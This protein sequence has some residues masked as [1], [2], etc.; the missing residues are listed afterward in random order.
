M[1]KKSAQGY[2]VSQEGYAVLRIGGRHKKLHRVIA[3]KVLGKPLPQ[4]SIVHHVNENR[5]DNR[6]CNL[7]IC[8]DR[9]YHNYIHARMRVLAAGLDPNL[10]R[11]CALGNHFELLSNFHNWKGGRQGKQHH[12]INCG[13]LVVIR[14]KQKHAAAGI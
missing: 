8:E 12:C 2:S 14:R 4:A 1:F 9:A 10:Y 3:E 6:N 13:R 7:V 11:H 5:T